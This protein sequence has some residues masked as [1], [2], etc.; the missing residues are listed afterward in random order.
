MSA[1]LDFCGFWVLQQANF[2]CFSIE[3]VLLC[4]AQSCNRNFVL[5]SENIFTFQLKADIGF[6]E[7]KEVVSSR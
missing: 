5:R 1:L 2:F 6:L 7:G 4:K 3:E